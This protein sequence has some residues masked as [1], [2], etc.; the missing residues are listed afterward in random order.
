[1]TIDP[2]HAYPLSAAPKKPPTLAIDVDIPASC[3][4]LTSLAQ[5]QVKVKPAVE[6]P[7]RKNS[8]IVILGD[9]NG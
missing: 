8:A 7:I 4:G 2:K 3:G 6:K 1:M 9:S 5:A